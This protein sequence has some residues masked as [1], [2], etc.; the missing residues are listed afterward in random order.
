MSNPPAA[1]SRSARRSTDRASPRRRAVGSVATNDTFTS[2]P[3]AISTTHDSRPAEANTRNPGTP[4]TS[5]SSTPVMPATT[6]GS[7]S[8]DTSPA[9]GSDRRPRRSHRIGTVVSSRRHPAPV[10]AAAVAW[11][12][13]QIA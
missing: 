7:A 11:S 10:S 9:A 4:R 2:V 3:T 1:A 8:T 6:P 12:A 5:A 13:D